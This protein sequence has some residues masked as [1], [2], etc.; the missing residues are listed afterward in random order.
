MNDI[1]IAR[2]QLIDAL[3]EVKSLAHDLTVDELDALIDEVTVLYE[4][5]S[6]MTEA[7][8]GVKS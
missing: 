2:I 3:N 4:R 5:F 6:D 8:T 1:V 7:R